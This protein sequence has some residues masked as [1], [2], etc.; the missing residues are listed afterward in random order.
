MSGTN[1]KDLFSSDKHS[2]ATLYYQWAIDAMSENIHEVTKVVSMFNSHISGVVSAL[3]N[4]FSNAMAERLNGK[5]QELKTVARGYRTFQNFRSAILFFNG[6]L[7][8]YPH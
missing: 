5:I 2:G 7:E 4:N 3:I 8:L 1:F 6:G